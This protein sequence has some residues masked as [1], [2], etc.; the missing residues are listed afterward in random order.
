MFN[1]VRVSLSWS[2]ESSE[3]ISRT[4]MLSFACRPAQS[5]AS[6][7]SELLDCLQSH[8]C[9]QSNGHVVAIVTVSMILDTIIDE[10]VILR[11]LH[12]GLF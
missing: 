5:T 4:K 1:I 11:V 6:S 9:G 3:F 10:T 8:I 2:S 12:I 7:V